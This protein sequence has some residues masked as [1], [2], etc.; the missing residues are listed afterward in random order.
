M[1]SS[2]AEQVAFL[3]NAEKVGRPWVRAGS[4]LH[5]SSILAFM[6]FS[7]TTIDALFFFY[8]LPPQYTHTH[9][10]IHFFFLSFFA[11]LVPALF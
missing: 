5:G 1:S 6:T 9:I 7:H 11:A 10:Y 4:L 3:A 8:L 2:S